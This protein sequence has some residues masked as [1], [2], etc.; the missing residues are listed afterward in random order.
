[1]TNEYSHLYK[2]RL[3]QPQVFF[4]RKSIE[5]HPDNDYLIMPQCL[6]IA[7]HRL[8]PLGVETKVVYVLLS[9]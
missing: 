3:S 7:V 5:H 6:L 2:R 9:S 8:P 1:C 4:M